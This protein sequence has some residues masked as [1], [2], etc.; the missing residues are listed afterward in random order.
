MLFAHK[1]IRTHNHIYSNE[2][3]QP[4][5]VVEVLSLCHHRKGAKSYAIVQLRRNA[6]SYSIQRKS[7]QH[8]KPNVLTANPKIVELR[9]VFCSR[10]RKKI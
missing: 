10:K 2:A 4:Q 9:T 3:R 7:K 8:A 1:L 6:Q 5:T